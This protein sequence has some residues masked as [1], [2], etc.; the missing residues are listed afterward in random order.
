MAST[1]ATQPVLIVAPEEGDALALEALLREHHIL[2]EIC[3]GAG[4]VRGRLATAG[5]LLLTE[6]ALQGE[7]VAALFTQ[8]GRQPPWSELPLIILTRA[9]TRAEWLLDLA[10]TAA[11]SVTLLERPLRAATLLRS[12]Q[13]A[14][15]ARRRQYQVRDLMLAQHDREAALRASEERLRMALEGADLGSWDVDLRTGKAVWNSR[16]GQ[17]L[18]YKEDAPATLERWHERIYPED[19]P[20]VTQAVERAREQRTALVVEHRLLRADDGELRWL[21]LFG[22][23]HYDANGVPVR[24]SGVSRDVTERKHLE[25]ER[26]RYLAALQEAD[27]RKDTFLATLSHELRNPLAPIRNAAEVLT[28]AQLDVTQLTWARSVIQ[29]QVTHMALL[30]DDLLD[31]ARIT[32]GKLRLRRQSCSLRSVVD[33]AVETSRPLLQKKEQQLTVR[34]PEDVPALN[35][36]PLRLA[37]VLSNLLSNAVK[38]TAPHGHIELSG[39]VQA[40]KLVLSVKDDG[41][42]IAPDRLGELF[43]MFAQ[44]PSAQRWSEG[45]LGIGLALAKGL[46]ELHGGTIQAASAG[47]G[48]GSEFTVRLPL[49][50]A[51]PVRPSAPRPAVAPVARLRRVLIA[52]D[53]QDAAESLAMLLT[54]DGFEVRT[55]YNGEDALALARGFRPEVALLDIGMPILDGYA[56]AQAMRRQ[57]GDA[58][59]LIALT[60]WGQ[61]ED[62]RRAFA[63]GFSAHLTK[64]VDPER[65]RDLLAE[66]SQHAAVRG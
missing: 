40:G 30:L 54:L 56:T 7:Q 21:A 34:I 4:A 45:G 64:P 66:A 29:R 62:K 27:R 31:L 37:Q 14:L 5:A 18:G 24:F 17:L 43:T 58:V 44:I 49:K 61:E 57:E 33:A 11:G 36:D 50:A 55:A 12:V 51:T 6:E 9:V 15:R 13:V 2:A 19:Q 63:A 52:D 23:F 26:E 10:V 1:E 22:R 20:M 53:N 41:I 16:H 39:A 28:S 65:L 3:P 59:R 32:S 35:A 47:P 38:Y 46:M 8:L 48:Q 42:G 60:G 25:S